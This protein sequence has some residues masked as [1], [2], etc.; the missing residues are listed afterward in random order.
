MNFKEAESRRCACIYRF[1]FPDGKSYIGK[2]KDL[3]NRIKI[4]VRNISEN[5][6]L[7]KVEEALV[8]FGLDSVSVDIISEPKNISE[9]DKDVVLSI[10]EIK[11]IR[12]L[13]TRHPDGYNVSIGGE[14]LGIPAECIETSGYSFGSSS[15]N[16]H[17]LL[18]GL[19][20]KFIRE[21][22]SIE[23]CAYDFGVDTS[24]VNNNLDKRKGL[25]CG[26]YMVRRKRYG[27]IPASIAPFKI[28]VIQKKV[29]NNI[30][31]D[32]I[33][34]R[35]KIKVTPSNRILK[36]N[37]EGEFCGEYET[38]TDAAISIGSSSVPKGVLIK[39]YIF[40]EHDG[41][42]IVQNIGKIE[43][44]TLRLPKYSEALDKV[45]NKD[46]NVKHDGWSKLINDFKVAQY[47]L[48]GNLL[49]VY[50]NI[51]IASY[52]TGIAYSGIWACV[53]GKTK[54]SK[55]FIWR[56]FDK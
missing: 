27:Q 46:F 33:V 51:K 52:K 21:Y 39:G 32:R 47:D 53:F 22:D 54:K 10:L 11:Y 42:E 17:V 56:K 12:E 9:K 24:V 7:T 30:Y 55:G 37:S 41:G 1:T 15:S 18:Y 35:D 43:K 44:K 16:K 29:I 36:Y 8:K 49:N 3:S 13:K 14:I 48:D 25:F 6:K 20:G 38:L 40:F 50:D 5:T 45:A 4:Y 26:K 31:E 28:E 2:T 23:K 19:D 34:Y